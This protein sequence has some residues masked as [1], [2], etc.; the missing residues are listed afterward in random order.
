[1]YV[2]MEQGSLGAPVAHPERRIS[3]SS[4][5]ALSSQPSPGGRSVPWG[6]V[7]GQPH[8]HICPVSSGL[9]ASQSSLL[10]FI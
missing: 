5:L 8:V 2:A 7:F 4:P 1:M 9:C 6:C 3:S 10:V